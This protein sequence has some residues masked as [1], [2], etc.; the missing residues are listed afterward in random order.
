MGEHAADDETP[1]PAPAP[2]DTAEEHQATSSAEVEEAAEQ[3]EELDQH[4]R[5]FH[6]TAGINPSRSQDS[7]GEPD[8]QPDDGR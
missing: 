5:S 1:R 7:T 6:D 8:E 4:S 2:E 3:A